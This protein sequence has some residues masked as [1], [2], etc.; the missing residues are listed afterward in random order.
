MSRMWITLLAALLGGCQSSDL[1]R[2]DVPVPDTWPHL[3]AE[4]S[5]ATAAA[6]L[7]DRPWAEVLPLPELT[8]LIDEALAGSSDLRIAVERI[9]LARAQYGLER[10]AMF[11]GIDLAGSA[12][13]QR[14]PGFDP[15]HV[16]EDCLYF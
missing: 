16:S 2:P 6:A 12:T 9:E 5:A 10:S 1:V 4:S 7:A 13:R 8:A 11:P 15:G 3:G 14:A